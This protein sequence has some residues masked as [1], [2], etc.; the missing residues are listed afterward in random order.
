MHILTKI[1]LGLG[2]V[3]L[4][5]SIIAV[6]AGGGSFMGD[7]VENPSGT[8]MW[9]GTSPTTYEG[10]LSFMGMYYVFVE[11]GSTVE[12]EL[13]DSDADSRFYPCEED[14]SC[15]LIEWAGYTYVGNI[16]VY[17]EGTWQVNFTGD[18]DVMIREQHIDLSGAVAFSMGCWGICCSILVLGLGL[19]F[20]F[21]LKD[22]AAAGV[23]YQPGAIGGPQVVGVHGAQ[24]A[25]VMHADGSVTAV[26]QP[27]VPQQQEGQYSQ[28]YDS[29]QQP[30]GGGF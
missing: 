18:G 1:T 9:T 17:V 23:H 3:M 30:P 2:G 6:V 11:E 24:Q 19:I 5:G 4:L 16:V 20:V 27:A 10:E 25:P 7:L 22:P 8:E 28:T 29:N 14:E 13:V 21:A 12:V 26:A 15:D